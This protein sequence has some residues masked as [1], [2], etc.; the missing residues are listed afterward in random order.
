MQNVE[1]NASSIIQWMEYKYWDLEDI[2]GFNL[3]MKNKLNA[4]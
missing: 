2:K 3:V 1:E 4:Y